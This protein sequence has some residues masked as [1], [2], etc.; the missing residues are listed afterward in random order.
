MKLQLDVPIISY[1]KKINYQSSILLMGSCFTEHIYGFLQKAKFDVAQNSHG[2]LFN[3]VSIKDAI[4][5][6]VFQKKYTDTDIF[7]EK[8]IWHSWMHHS[9]FSNTDK[10][11]I[12]ENINST[13]EKFHTFFKKTTTIIITLGSAFA[14][15][16]KEKNFFVSNNHR[17]DANLFE[18]KLLSIDQIFLELEEIKLMLQKI[19]PAI[20]IIFTISPVRHIKDGIVENNRSKA[21]L[22]EAVH[23]FCDKKSNSFYFPAY[24]IVLDVLRDY[25]FFDVDMVHPNFLATNLV[26]NYFLENCIEESC[27]PLIQKLQ[28]LSNSLQHKAQHQDSKAHQKFLKE[29]LL[30]CEKLMDQ[31]SFLNLENEMQFFKSKL[32]P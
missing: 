2:N 28:Q 27:V 22:L 15:W 14:Y 5:E 32:N 1:K 13:N 7:L 31:Y 17:L 30:L 10:N 16:H 18:K 11:I 6:I 8:D 19:N 4:K 9:K 24:E 29:Q 20:E 12:L 3:P 21:R 25:R 26:W 23:D